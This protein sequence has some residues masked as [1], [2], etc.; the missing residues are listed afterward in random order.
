MADG[1][2][3]VPLSEQE[4]RISWLR[5]RGVLIEFPNE[6][7]K[8]ADINIVV[9]RAAGAFGRVYLAGDEKDII[10]ASEAAIKAIEAVDG[11]VE[12]KK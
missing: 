9:I 8:A 12:K 3:E 11:T 1:A 4:E 6:A 10:V 5:D 2:P 7:E